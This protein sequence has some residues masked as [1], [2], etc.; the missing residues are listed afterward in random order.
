MVTS[1]T[2]QWELSVRPSAA[3]YNAGVATWRADFFKD[4]D[5]VSPSRSMIISANSD[6][7]VV[8]EVVDEM[9]DAACVEIHSPN[10]LRALH[11]APSHHSA[12]ATLT[13][14]A[15]APLKLYRSI[16]S[17]SKAALAAAISSRRRSVFSISW[18]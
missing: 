3:A 1:A 8:K 2:F 9:G 12:G 17:R 18:S 11:E 5:D 14:R 7:E 4:W 15:L 16:T 6:D 13:S 10:L